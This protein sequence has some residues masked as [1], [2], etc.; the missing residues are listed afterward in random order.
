MANRDTPYGFKPL[1]GPFRAQ[2]Y[3]LAAA[4]SAIGVGDLLV[5]GTDGCVDL[6]AASATQIVGVALEAKG[7]SNAGEILIS[8]HPETIYVAQCD[9]GTAIA[10]TDMNLNFNIVATASANGVSKMEID[11]NTGAV[12]AA[13]PVRA[14]RLHKAVDN[15]FGEFNKI[16]VKINAHVYNGDKLGL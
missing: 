2:K 16:E 10:Q 9:D 12:T 3:Q 11:S 14:I 4:N 5:Q 1:R 15:A 8:D 7:A 6:A 13:L